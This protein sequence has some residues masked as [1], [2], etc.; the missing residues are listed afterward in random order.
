MNHLSLYLLAFIGGLAAEM[1]DL[2]HK[3]K[4]YLPTYIKTKF[5]WCM[6]FVMSSLG[7]LLVFL[8]IDT[9]TV[10]TKMLAFNIGATAPMILSQLSSKPQQIDES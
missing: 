4:G 3:R 1:L 10:I 7:S 6:V 8:Y 2:S 5:Y 9:G